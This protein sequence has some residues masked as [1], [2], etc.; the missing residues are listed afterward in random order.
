VFKLYY[1]D[2]DKIETDEFVGTRF[3]KENQLEVIGWS[4]KSATSKM[5]VVKCSICEK[6]PELYGDGL[7]RSIKSSLILGQV[8]CGCSVSARRDE[9]YYKIVCQRKAGELGYVF[10]GW[11][12][13]FTDRKTKLSLECKTHGIWSSGIINNFINRNVGCPGCRFEA[14]GKRAS[15]PDEEFVRDFFATGSF[16]EGTTFARSTTEDFKGHR[17]YWKVFC[18]DCLQNVEA[19]SATLMKGNRSCGCAKQRQTEAYINLIKDNDNIIAIKFGISNNSLIRVSQQQRV[20]GLDVVLHKVYKFPNI[21]D[22]KAAERECI[23]TLTC[24]VV[25]R[26]LLPDGYSETTYPHN[27]EDIVEIY[28]KFNG[29][30]MKGTEYVISDRVG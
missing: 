8:P 29:S 28:E 14:V 18:P 2:F 16:S 7:F 23:N 25:D 26:Q 19:R 21:S 4:G 10:H 1:S 30:L 15:K 6:D 11:A 22:C 24:G 9:R 20:S 5:Y 13:E 27:I 12:G 3:G 17:P